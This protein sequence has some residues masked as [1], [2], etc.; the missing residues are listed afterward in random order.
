MGLVIA[1]VGSMTII[2]LVVG[3]AGAMAAARF[4]SAL[5]YDVKPSDTRSIAAPLVCLIL[6]CALSALL[7]VLRATR[8]DPTTALRIE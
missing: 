3:A 7:P 5:L 1:D 8:V 6:A 4:I 2:G